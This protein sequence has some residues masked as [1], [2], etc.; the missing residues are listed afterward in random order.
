[1]TEY[2]LLLACRHCGRGELCCVG[3]RDNSLSDVILDKDIG[4]SR[5]GIAE[6]EN[7]G[8]AGRGTNLQ[9][10]REVGNGEK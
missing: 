7:I 10:L 9:C 2:R 4:A 1:M 8:A 3:L 6:Y 5:I